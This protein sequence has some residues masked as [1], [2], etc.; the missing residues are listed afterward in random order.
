MAEATPKAFVGQVFQRQLRALA[1]YNE[2]MAVA[3]KNAGPAAWATPVDEDGKP[4][5][6]ADLA[7]ACSRKEQGDQF[8]AAVGDGNAPGT[9]G[10]LSLCQLQ[11]DFVASLERAYRA[12]RLCACRSRLHAA[13]RAAGHSHPRGPVLGGLLGYAVRLDRLNK[14]ETPRT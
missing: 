9:V 3:A 8:V 1:L 4:V 5:T 10:D 6:L 13:A 2:Q 11:G 14:S 7:N 12:R